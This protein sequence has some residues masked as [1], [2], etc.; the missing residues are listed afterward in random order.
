MYTMSDIL[1]ARET[2][3]VDEN[4]SIQAIKSAYRKIAL[5]IHPDHNQSSNATVEMQ[6][7]NNAYEVLVKTENGKKIIADDNMDEQP[8]NVDD[9]IERLFQFFQYFNKPRRADPSD[10]I[11]EEAFQ[12]I[13]RDIKDTIKSHDGLVLPDYEKLFG[14]SAYQIER[15]LKHCAEYDGHRFC[16][17]HQG[18]RPEV[19]VGLLRYLTDYVPNTKNRCELDLSENELN[20]PEVVEMLKHFLEHAKSQWRLE[21]NK[22]HLNLTK[23]LGD[24]FAKSSSIYSL[25]LDENNFSKKDAESIIQ[26]LQTN[27]Y[28]EEFSIADNY[29]YGQ[30]LFDIAASVEHSQHL[31]SIAFSIQGTP[32]LYYDNIDTKIFMKVLNTCLR[33]KNQLSNISLRSKPFDDDRLIFDSSWPIT[34]INP[35]ITTL[36]FDGLDVSPSVLQSFLT[37]NV[38]NLKSLWI[39]SKKLSHETLIALASAINQMNA[40]EE[41]YL[42]GDVGSPEDQN[43]MIE[44]ARKHKTLNKLFLSKRMVDIPREDTQNK[45]QSTSVN[46]IK[47]DSKIMQD[48]TETDNTHDNIAFSS[49]EFNH[50]MMEIDEIIKT[51]AD[52]FKF[53]SLDDKKYTSKG[54]LSRWN[55]DHISLSQLEI[56][57]DMR[58][59]GDFARIDLSEENFLPPHLSSAIIRK[60]KAHYISD[61]THSAQSA[62]VELNLSRLNFTGHAK[63]LIAFVSHPQSTLVKLD[64]SHTKLSPSELS[65][66]IKVIAN[67][68]TLTDLSLP[69]AGYT[70][71]MFERDYMHDP[72]SCCL[73]IANM[74]RLNKVLRAIE[75]TSGG[76]MN[77]ND[78]SSLLSSLGK[79]YIKS[80]EHHSSIIENVYNFFKKEKAHSSSKNVVSTDQQ[81]NHSIESLILRVANYSADE[82]L[83]LVLKTNSSLKKLILDSRNSSFNDYSNTFKAALSS[84]SLTDLSLINY[85]LGS[86]Y[87]SGL[88]L[89]TLQKSLLTSI[90]IVNGNVSIDVIN[91]LKGLP[92]KLLNL[93]G[94]QMYLNR[95][96]EIL[97]ELIS[98][99][100]ATLESLDLS[101][102]NLGKTLDHCAPAK[103]SHFLNALSAILRDCH[104]LTQLN[105]ANNSGFTL[106]DILRFL[107]SLR[108]NHSNLID[109]KC[110]V[111]EHNYHGAL[112]QKH[113]AEY[114]NFYLAEMNL[115]NTLLSK[116][117][118]TMTSKHS[119]WTDLEQLYK[120]QISKL[121]VDIKKL[122]DFKL[123]G[124]LFD[125][126]LRTKPNTD[127]K[128][129]PVH[130]KIVSYAMDGKYELFHEALMNWKAEKGDTEDQI[131]LHASLIMDLINETLFL[132][133]NSIN[134]FQIQGDEWASSYNHQPHDA[135]SYEKKLV[136]IEMAEMQQETDSNKRYYKR[137]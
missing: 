101:R 112:L 39:S 29:F 97:L 40:L 90:T 43:V 30:S 89:R 27:T 96:G 92:L 34:E 23:D 56:L 5:K 20:H 2:L 47:P 131:D 105:I 12:Q 111:P 75:I 116:H 16:L 62:L 127:F 133:A 28:L 66:L 115:K 70:L 93:A 85:D 41:L 44:A 3:G 46:K 31:Q 63:D 125:Q 42:P 88:E 76:L 137:G 65:E 98:Q 118:D 136:I 17:S 50:L 26:I 10:F 79:T 86:H 117:H 84:S 103:I 113:I 69:V 71:F 122:I 129:S 124:T 74:L 25:H 78:L 104:Q 94:N 51:G 123:H 126:L 128:Y 119:A 64:L 114:V 91:A 95:G 21:L 108:A 58:L 60:L 6:Q 45:K 13:L 59:T 110:T 135:L 77:K 81:P 109:I 8:D 73:D 11:S 87:V 68:K 9:E 14:V 132:Y 121:L 19:L 48:K 15:L 55:D 49:E 106:Y 120:N 37:T 32:T 72:N 100:S 80:K 1:N 24:H 35:R 134:V 82:Q 61:N 57:M 54:R 83:A 107:H 52:T 7:M 36:H 130:A 102:N 4:S 99:K 38:P 22:C 67:H 33:N 53:K 18:F